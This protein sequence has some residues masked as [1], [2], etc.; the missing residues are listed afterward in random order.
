MNCMVAYERFKGHCLLW[1]DADL[2]TSFLTL[3]RVNLRKRLEL[4]VMAA[5]F[6]AQTK[7]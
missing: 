2:D 7:T 3:K 1:D 4:C 5:R 6:G